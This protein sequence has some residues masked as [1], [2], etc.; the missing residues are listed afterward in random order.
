MLFCV[1]LQLTALRRVNYRRAKREKQHQSVS[2]CVYVCVCER[3]YENFLIIARTCFD[4]CDSHEKSVAKVLF[5][6]YKILEKRRR[7]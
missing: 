2:M 3:E 5:L 1:R 7:P 6:G 4:C